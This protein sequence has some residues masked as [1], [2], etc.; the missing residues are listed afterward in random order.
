MGMHELS[1]TGVMP[2]GVTGMPARY[3]TNASLD[4]Q[5]ILTRPVLAL[6][7]RILPDL[8]LTLPTAD[9]LGSHDVRSVTCGP[10]SLVVRR[11]P[12]AWSQ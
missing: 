5:R 7:V 1:R 4:Q 2:A 6:P 3:M 10:T 9:V 11:H 8:S 12:R